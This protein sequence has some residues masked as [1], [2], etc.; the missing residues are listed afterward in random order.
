MVSTV[1]TGFTF[2]QSGSNYAWT[3]NTFF[4]VTITQA[5]DYLLVNAF[6]DAFS[7]NLG[8]IWVRKIQITETPPPSSFTLSSSTPSLTCGATTPV[9]YT[10]NNGNNTTG[11]TGYNWNLGATPNGWLYNGNPAPAT[12]T[13]GAT[14]NTLTLTPDCGKVLSSI[15]ATVAANGANYN[16]N[17]ASISIL[18]PS[19]SISGS[20]SICSASTNYTIN[21]LVCNSSIAWSSPPAGLATLSS[22]TTSPTTLTYGGTSGSFSLTANVTSCGVQTPVTLPVHVGPYSVAD[23]VL[24]GNNGSI[25]WCPNQTMSF[26][27]SGANGV[28]G[29]TGTNYTWS[30]PTGF[31][32]VY[33]GGSY[34]AIKAPSSTYPPTGS[35]SVNFTEPCGTTVTKSVFLAYSSSA[36]GSSSPYTV[37]PNPASS[38]LTISCISLQNN[39]NIAAVQITNLGGTVLSSNSWNNTNQ[40]VQVPVYFLSPG[41]YIARTYNGT[42]W[43]ANQFIK[44]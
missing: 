40:T 2:S 25:Y 9:T 4:E 31:T 12:V 24:S 26:G 8:S 43:Y 7:N 38:Y 35:L 37:S 29:A 30:L 21:G 36:C 23:Y 11:I 33:N 15:S 16:T 19:Y 41:T 20:N 44:Q 14:I 3:S 34:V 18:Q 6:P 13:T 1:S 32:V 27:V 39:C 42:Q 5:A 10:V 17:S 22:L 28:N